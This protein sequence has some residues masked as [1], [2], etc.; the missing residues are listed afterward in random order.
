MKHSIV[1]ALA[2]SFALGGAASAQ[3]SAAKPVDPVVAR[4]NGAEIHRSDVIR[5]FERLPAQ[6]QQM[7]PE[8]VFPMLVDRVVE[9]KLLTDA[10]YKA[11]LQSDE[12]VKAEVHL[13]EEQAVERAYLRKV[14]AERIKEDAVLAAYKKFVADFKPQ[15]EVKASHIL[16]ETEAEANAIIAELN[17]GGDFAKIA[18]EKSKDTG[19]AEHGGDLGFFPAEAMVEP[20][21]KA[22][23]A[24]KKGEISKTPVKTTYGWHVIKVEDR[25]LSPIPPFEQERQQI[26]QK[27]R[28]EIADAV[29]K[30]LRSAAKVE[31]FNFDGTPVS[32]D[33]AKS[34]KADKPAKKKK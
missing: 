11:G 8:T 4:V 23:F 6:V 30:D 10:G 16:V 9:Q 21:A 25:R 20:F 3:S 18:K 34:D 29:V 32:A 2:L 22:A 14:F 7:P 33:K 31:T 27:M 13:A 17:K 24:M 1:F 19:S 12:M 26:E 15:D 5:L 28:E